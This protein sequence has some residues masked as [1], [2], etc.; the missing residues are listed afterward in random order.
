[1]KARLTTVAAAAVA[2]SLGTL[3]AAADHGGA[4]GSTAT[5]TVQG[6]ALSITV[7]ADAGNLGTRA[8]TG[9][10]MRV[11]GGLGQVVVRDARGASA[12]SGWVASA[13]STPFTSE[14]GPA[15][16]AA[17]VGYTAGRI[18]R[19]GTATYAANDP[20]DLSRLTPVV[21]ASEITGNNTATWNPTISV[22]IPGGMPA[23]VYA[24]TITH[25]V[26]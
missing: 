1:M 20:T 14:S 8:S 6:G 16:P 21:T 11:R 3:P 2:L 17:A 18:G 19:V 4:T 26:S 24:G 25:S 10:R 23:G 12:G 13:V 7:R 22:T 9:R 15:I 5:V